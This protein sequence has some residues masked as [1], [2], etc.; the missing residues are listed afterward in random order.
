M[1]IFCWKRPWKPW[2]W[3]EKIARHPVSAC[4]I[5]SDI[6][7]ARDR[8]NVLVDT[9]Y[10]SLS[11][12]GKTHQ[13]HTWYHVR[14][15]HTYFHT[16]KVEIRYACFYFTYWILRSYHSVCIISYH[17][18]HSVCISC[19]RRDSTVGIESW[20]CNYHYWLYIVSRS[21]AKG[22]PF[23]VML[24]PFSPLFQKKVV[25]FWSP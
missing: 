24:V 11:S 5:D 22:P 13:I 21:L 8:D 6:S 25:P 23:E 15:Q 12:G 14:S 4:I 3:Y 7:T 10:V 19:T 9:L 18:Y 1:T 2:N 17:S 20:N 16:L